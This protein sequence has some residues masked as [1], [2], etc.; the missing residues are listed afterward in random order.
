M[1]GLE[2]D[3]DAQF[4]YVDLYDAAELG[5][6]CRLRTVRPSNDEAE[7][8]LRDGMTLASEDRNRVASA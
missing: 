1:D 7:L 6:H 3:C 8:I 5:A 2:S 4:F